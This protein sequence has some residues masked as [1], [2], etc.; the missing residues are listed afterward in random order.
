[1]E[2]KR[3]KKSRRPSRL[4]SVGIGLQLSAIVLAVVAF[5]FPFYVINFTGGVIDN[6][7][8][9]N[10][11]VSFK[12]RTYSCEF[13]N[14]LNSSLDTSAS[15]SYND[16][17]G[18]ECIP[19]LIPAVHYSDLSFVMN[20]CLTFLVLGC[21]CSLVVII[22][23]S[24]MSFK[25]TCRLCSM[26]SVTLIISLTPIIC[27]IIAVLC[28]LEI[29]KVFEKETN[30]GSTSSDVNDLSLCQSLWCNSFLG[31]G[32]AGSVFANASVKWKPS[33]GWILAIVAA[34]I[35][36]F[37]CIFTVCAPLFIKNDHNHGRH[38]RGSNHILINQ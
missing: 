4:L 27:F 34:F 14:S 10:S 8:S 28:L 15:F 29:T 5:F 38:H 6:I 19:I 23:Q 7:A 13:T 24:I 9:T 2:M 30:S 11:K 33:I 12:L 17:A 22:F 35:S 36:L 16:Y 3:E 32:S 1:M 31:S 18:I 21:A 26:K 37:S 25:E 20:R